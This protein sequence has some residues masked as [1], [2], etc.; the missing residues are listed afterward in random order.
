MGLTA[1]HTGKSQLGEHEQ[2]KTVEGC[3]VRRVEDGIG[4]AEVVVDV[5]DLGRIL[6]AGDPHGGWRNG[7]RCRTNRNDNP[8]SRSVSARQDQVSV[9]PALAA[10]SMMY[11][12]RGQ[13]ETTR[14]NGM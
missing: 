1:N 10:E 5:A 14:D 11:G 13:K 6:Q 3:R 2:V 4:A 12:G 9:L 7:S 8:G